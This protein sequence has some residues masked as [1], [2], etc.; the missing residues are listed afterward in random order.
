MKRG[1]IWYGTIAQRVHELA[2]AFGMEVLI[3]QSLIP[4][5]K[6]KEGR[7]PLNELLRESDVVSLHCPLSEYS[8]IL[9]G[10]E[11][12]EMM[13]DS[14][15]LINMA[16]GSIVDENALYHDLKNNEIA[17]TLTDVLAT[18]NSPPHH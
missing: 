14:A 6:A 2:E 9:I 8:R 17:N 5:K 7:I 3:S 1:L 4:S 12:L 11:E 18:E 13:K 16:R 15:V 10:K